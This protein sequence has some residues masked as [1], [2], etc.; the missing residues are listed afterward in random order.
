MPTGKATGTDGVHAELFERHADKSANQLARIFE[1]MIHTQGRLP[2]QLRTGII[3]LMHIK[4]LTEQPANN[5]PIA[6]LNTVMKVLTRIHSSTLHS[7]M[8]QLVP[9]SQTGFIRGRTMTENLITL[10]DA[11]HWA[12]T[13]YPSAILLSLDFEKAYHRLHWPFMHD[14]LKN[15][16]FDPR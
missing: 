8:P 5:R 16:R 1:K 14:V 4:G 11:M 2:K 6:L 10:Q 13:Y 15:M 9:Q 12:R 3:V 7:I